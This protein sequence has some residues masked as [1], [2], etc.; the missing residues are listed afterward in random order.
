[1]Q[2]Q[3]TPVVSGMFVIKSA[4]LT[5]RYRYRIQNGTMSTRYLLGNNYIR[6]SNT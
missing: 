2:E 6:S 1:M 4:R 3:I 5:V